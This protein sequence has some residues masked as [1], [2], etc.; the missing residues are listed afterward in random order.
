MKQGFK[1]LFIYIII[2][3]LLVFLFPSFTYNHVI[4]S[5]ICY[6]II[7]IIY[8]FICS[9]KELLKDLKEIKNNFK[10]FLPIILK[11]SLSCFIIMIL[12]NYIIQLSIKTL[13]TNEL[14]NRTLLEN[15]LFLSLLYLLLI[16]PCLEE[17]IFR[18][19]FKNI[20]NSKVYIILTSLLFASLHILS[21]TNFPEYIY[22]IP[23]F[24]IGF[25]FSNIYNKTKN[26]YASLL[27]HIIHNILCVII[28]MVF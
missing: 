21:S 17:Y 18:F 23:Y 24:V 3:S 9:R 26:Y 2:T 5:N 4:L 13:P 6:S 14:N 25:G 27:G 11:Y 1:N 19:S 15:N 8:F 10:K 7:L 22:I 12:L 20:K 16:A 28:I